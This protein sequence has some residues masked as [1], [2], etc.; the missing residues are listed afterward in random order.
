L[1]FQDWERR[2]CRGLDALATGPATLVPA[3]ARPPAYPAA[4]GDDWIEPAPGG[5]R[6]SAGEQ[7]RITV[8]V[9]DD[10]PGVR[11]G[12]ESLVR[13]ARDLVLLGSASG[14]EEAVVLTTRLRPRVVVMDLAMPGVDGV[15]ATRRVRRQDP[16]PVVVA[17]SGSHELIRD[18]VAAGASFTVL[19]DVDPGRLLEV[20]RTAAGR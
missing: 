18:A 1:A 2:H 7:D 3:E 14:G 9:V 11:C 10:H 8:L 16:A 20:I 6:S 13:S 15:E 4:G 12:L 19:K 17:L 5:P